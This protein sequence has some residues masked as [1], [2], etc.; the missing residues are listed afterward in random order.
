MVS[1][2]IEQIEELIRKYRE[3]EQALRF[4]RIHIT[5]NLRAFSQKELECMAMDG[6]IK[7][8][9]IPEDLQTE[10]SKLMAHACMEEKK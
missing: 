5:N 6:I 7:H 2:L 10:H 4:A 9:D 8:S 3:M 1:E